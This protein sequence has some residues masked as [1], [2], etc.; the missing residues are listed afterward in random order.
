MKLLLLTLT[1]AG[2]KVPENTDPAQRYVGFFTLVLRQPV[3]I[4]ISPDPPATLSP[5]GAEGIPRS[6]SHPFPLGIISIPPGPGFLEKEKAVAAHP[7]REAG[8]RRQRKCLD[9]RGP[10]SPSPI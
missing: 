10:G 3:P 8:M 7:G 2:G 6:Q 4:N 5:T 9:K 1:N